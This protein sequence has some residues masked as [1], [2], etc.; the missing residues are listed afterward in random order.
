MKIRIENVL[1]LSHES[2]GQIKGSDEIHAVPMEGHRNIS[3]CIGDKFY[4]IE[5]PESGILTWDE[6]RR[7]IGESDKTEDGNA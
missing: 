7:Q 1:Q 2:F 4:E 5:V 6:V 3:L